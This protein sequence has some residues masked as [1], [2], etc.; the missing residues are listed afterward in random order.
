MAS[1]PRPEP[2]EA[3]PVEGPPDF[4]ARLGTIPHDLRDPD[5][6][7]ALHLDPSLPFDPQAKAALILDARS[8]SRRFLLP[9][10]RPFA[11]T[12]IVLVALF[13]LVVPRALASSRLLHWLIYVGLR[14]FVTPAANFLILRH[15]Q[16]GSQLVSFIAANAP[17]PVPTSP[18]RPLR[19]ADVK[20]DLF[21]RHDLN[22]YNFLINLNS[23][24]QA[25]GRSLSSPARVDFDP[26]LDTPIPFEGFP[27]RWTNFLDLFSAIE[28][29]TP[30]YELLLTQRDFSRANHSL[31]LDETM[32]IYAA[33][34]L[35]DPTHL[36]LVNNRH[37]LVPLSALRAAFRLVIHGLGTEMLHAVLVRH[38]R[39]RAGGGASRGPLG[40]QG[41]WTVPP[42]GGSRGESN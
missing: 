12:F 42:G 16:L 13:R 38:K 36:G 22:L 29:Y 26:I 14:T 8:F 17:V 35:G 3:E 41:L 33:Q 6:W 25:E 18:L 20:D 32:A 21:L 24:L 27:D 34:I 30:L 23:A 9:L 28:L 15:F 37:P 7:L 4:I 10:I 31:Q 2:P 11:R 39:V 1:D 40:L 19:L 5:P